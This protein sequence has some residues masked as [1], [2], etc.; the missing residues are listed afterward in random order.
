MPRNSHIKIIGKLAHL[1][2]E[3][4]AG[5]LVALEQTLHREWLTQDQ[6]TAPQVLQV[7]IVK[8]FRC[9]ARGEQQ[10]S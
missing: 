2:Q 7:R 8:H 4:R 6:L 1:G 3:R 5:E 10:A 9:I